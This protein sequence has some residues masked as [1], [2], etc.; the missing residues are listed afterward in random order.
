MIEITDKTKMVIFNNT[1]IDFYSNTCGPCRKMM[2][3]LEDLEK[4][5]TNLSF[6]K[7]NAVENPEL[8]KKF[9]VSGL[10]TIIIYKNGEIIKKN[11]GLT[12]KTVLKEVIGDIN[13]Q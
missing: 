11:I 10:P 13:V 4:E 6:Y 9:E 12:N 8:V 3:I 1:I 2:P 7:V 5:F